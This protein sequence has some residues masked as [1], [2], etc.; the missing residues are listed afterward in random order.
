MARAANAAALA[1]ADAR[2]AFLTTGQVPAAVRAEVAQSW[3]R[4]AAFGVVERAMAPVELTDD[5]LRS[6]RD[7]HPLALAMPVIRRLLVAHALEDELLVAV[8]DAN[9]RLLWVEGQPACGARRSGCTSS[10]ARSGMR[11][12]PARTPR[13]GARHEPGFTHLRRRALPASGARWSC[14]AAPV[15]SPYG[16]AARGHRRHR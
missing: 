15:Y 8:G 13:R 5:S 16:A 10:R 11:R 12:M 1:V 3:Q 4:S 7:S 14:S 6:Y 9:G 2:E